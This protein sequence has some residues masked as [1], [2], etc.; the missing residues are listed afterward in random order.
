MGQTQQCDHPLDYIENDEVT[1]DEHERICLGI[2][3]DSDPDDE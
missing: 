3:P 2:D 1:A